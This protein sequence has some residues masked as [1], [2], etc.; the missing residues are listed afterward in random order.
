MKTKLYGLDHARALAIILVFIYHYGRLFESPKEVTIIGKFGWTGVDLFFV[1]SGFLIAS[2]LFLK[3]TTQNE[4]ISFK[5]FFV[6]RFFRIIPAYFVVVFLYFL[7]PALR[8]REAPAPL[9]KYLTFTQNLGLDLRY[10]GTFSHAWSLCIEEQFYLLLPVI[11]I[12][13]IYYR[14]L[15]K[16]WIIIASLFVLGFAA[17]VYCWYTFVVPTTATGTGWV[18]WYRYI[19]YPTYARLDGLLAGIS[20]AA[21]F[22]FKPVLKERLTRHGNLWLFTGLL[23]LVGAYFI[24][25]NEQSMIASLVGF[26]LTDIGYGFLV[27][28]AVSHTSFL[29]KVSLRVTTRLAEWSYA[30]YLTHK[31]VIHVTQQYVS[32]GNIQKD[33]T[34]MFIICIASSL[35]AG[36]VLHVVIEKPFL[37]LRTR[38]L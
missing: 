20:I 4:D 27:L 22:A 14:A 30:I 17:R 34:W 13:L 18:Y 29:Y 9:W 10:Q 36:Y 12:I 38:L 3:T 37:K 11:L 19:Y 5:E 35:L 16:G 6:K 32:K 33:S 28:G 7:F 21:V 31:I 2:Q 24:C 25:S 15:K 1:L 26:P 23:I 8:E